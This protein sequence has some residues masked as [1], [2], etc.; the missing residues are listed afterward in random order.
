MPPPSAAWFESNRGI[1]L[2][3]LPPRPFLQCFETKGP[4][5]V[6]GSEVVLDAK[7][8]NQTENVKALP[9][10]D[11]PDA[12]LDAEKKG[13]VDKAQGNPTAAF[14]NRGPSAETLW[15]WVGHHSQEPSDLCCILLGDFL[16]RAEPLSRA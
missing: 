6:I 14:D 10:Y 13:G 12:H 8:D 16:A 2:Q 3:N 11:L 7:V 15:R 9:C 4:P 1:G 5:P